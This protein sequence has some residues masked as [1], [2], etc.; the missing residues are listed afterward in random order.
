LPAIYIYMANISKLGTV[1]LT[2]V[3]DFLQLGKSDELVDYFI[4]LL[5]CLNNG[6]GIIL[7]RFPENCPSIICGIITNREQFKDWVEPFLRWI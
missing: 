7:K 5:T 6:V 1:N 3:E 4:W 2:T